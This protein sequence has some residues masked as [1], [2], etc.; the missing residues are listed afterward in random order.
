MNEALFCFQLPW[1][2]IAGFS[3]STMASCPTKGVSLPT[4]TI[5]KSREAPLRLSDMLCI[6]SAKVGD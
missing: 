2:V 5:A 3:L 6:P 1:N 4:A